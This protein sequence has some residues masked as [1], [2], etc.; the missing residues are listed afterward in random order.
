MEH[1]AFVHEE[2]G[3]L[4]DIEGEH[5]TQ[6][7][8]P[9]AES[10]PEGDPGTTHFSALDQVGH[11]RFKQGNRRTPGSDRHQHEEHH[12]HQLPE[13]HVAEGKRQA[14][15]HQPRSFARVQARRE[16]NRKQ[17]QASHQGNEGIE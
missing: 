5:R 14:D 9:A 2:L 17:C 1:P 3:L 4:P 15:E 16:N 7:D 11:H 6:T 10:Q 8:K 13:R 12:P